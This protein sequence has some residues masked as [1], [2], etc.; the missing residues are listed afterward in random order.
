MPGK[1]LHKFFL[2][3]VFPS[4]LAIILF[5]LSIFVVILP[6]FEENIM[7]KKKE[8]ISELTNTAWSLLEEF[9]REYR[10]QKFS[11]EEAQQLAASRIEQIRYGKENKDYFWIIDMH[12][13]M[14]MHPYRGE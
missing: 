14:I 6:S 5:I 3:I 8:M 12:P 9:D 11:R 1:G 4:I 2:S 7:D 10:Q 13:T